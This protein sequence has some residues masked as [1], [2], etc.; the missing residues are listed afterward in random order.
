MTCWSSNIIKIFF[1]F[2]F[3]A[4]N[5]KYAETKKNNKRQKTSREQNN[6]PQISL[7]YGQI[8]VIHSHLR[9][10]TLIVSVEYKSLSAG[11]ELSSLDL[12][13]WLVANR[14][15]DVVVVVVVDVVDVVK[16]K[17]TSSL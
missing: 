13:S 9:S 15:S 16:S 5:I 17:T 11:V 6:H 14:K 1:I 2:S 8:K 10:L 7:K 4:E 12:Y 3:T